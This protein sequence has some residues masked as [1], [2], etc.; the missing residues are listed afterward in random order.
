MVSA[1]VRGVENCL[2]DS[3]PDVIAPAL[4]VLSQAQSLDM[5]LDQDCVSLTSVLCGKLIHGKSDA[6]GQA[7]ASCVRLLLLVL[8]SLSVFGLPELTI[9]V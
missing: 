1:S 3:N 2:H 9:V 5:S 6:I 7:A 4:H 8:L